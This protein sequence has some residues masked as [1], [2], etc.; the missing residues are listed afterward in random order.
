MNVAQALNVKVNGNVVV[1]NGWTGL[2]SASANGIQLV[3]NAFSFNN[4]KRWGNSAQAGVKLTHALDGV[5]VDNLFEHNASNGL[6][7]DQGC[8][9]TNPSNAWFTIARNVFDNNDGKGLF[10]EV[11]RHAVIA[12]NVAHDNGETGIASFGTRSVRIWNNTAVDNNQSSANYV[13]NISVVDDNRC[14]SND[15]LP[16]GKTCTAANGVDPLASGNWDD[17]EPSS[18]GPLANTCNA[19]DV[20]L[21]NN[22]ISGSGTAARPLLNVSIPAKTY[23]ASLAVTSN[24]YQAY[25][26]SSAGSPANL[27]TW[28]TT[29]STVSAYT[30]LAAFKAGVAGREAN[31]VERSGGSTHPF[32]V[33]YAAKNFTQNTGNSDV[34]GRG[35]TLPSEVLKA[36][37]WP[38]TNAPQ[39]SKRIGAIEWRGKTSGGGTTTPPVGCQAGAAVHHVAHPTNGDHLYTLSSSERS[40]AIANYGYVDRGVAFGAFNTDA[41]LA[42]VYRLTNATTRDRLVTIDANEAASAVANYG[43]TQDGVGFYA[44]AEAGVCRVPVWRLRAGNMHVL[45]ASASERQS[46]LASGYV[47]EGL[48]FYATVAP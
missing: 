6:W 37:T 26:R 7:C 8:G 31:G 16:G 14:F 9:A 47:D 36:V 25:Y 19:V 27:V 35:A 33:N 12:S 28:Q 41:T 34:W 29:A 38:A 3:G 23:A 15:T 17:C 20:T 5:I 21:M 48:R 2:L 42:P 24:D 44:Y 11:S 43:Y 4:V 32:F 10:Y 13:A 39:P 46:L 1:N 18:V 40:S 30:T 22:I 45:T